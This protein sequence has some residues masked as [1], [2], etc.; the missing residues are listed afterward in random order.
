[1]MKHRSHSAGLGTVFI[2]S[3]DMRRRSL[4]SMTQVSKGSG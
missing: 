2:A 4:G 1:M 3:V